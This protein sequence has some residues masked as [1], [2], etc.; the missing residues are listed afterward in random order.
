MRI[1]SLHNLYDFW[2]SNLAFL[3]FKVVYLTPQVSNQ[4]IYGGKGCAPG[5]M[6]T[7]VVKKPEKIYLKV[8]KKLE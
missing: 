6:R 3:N 2:F 4:A 8:L 5:G 7:R 1:K